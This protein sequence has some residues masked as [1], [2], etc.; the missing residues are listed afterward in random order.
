LLLHA[1]GIL[2][3]W[4]VVALAARATRPRHAAAFAAGFATAW[5]TLPAAAD[6]T[7]V[8]IVATAGAGSALWKPQWP[9]IALVWSGALAAVWTNVLHA[10]AWPAVPA[11]ALAL[12][13]PM[14]AMALAVRRA[15]FAPARLRDEALVIVAAFALAVAAAPAVETG[16]RSAVMLKAVPLGAQSSAGT[17]WALV[18]AAG[19]AVLGGFYSLWKRR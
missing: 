13:L 14:L 16:F 2:C 19:C 4:S 12:A 3:G 6:P 15:A 9:M 7:W 8:A 17:S 18:L 1:L 5:P 11:H 10:L